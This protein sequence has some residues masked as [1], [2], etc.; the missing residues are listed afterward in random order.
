MSYTELK[1]TY[2]KAK[3]EYKCEWCAKKITIG[4]KHM[5]RSYIF[6]GEF[7]SGRMHLECDNAY[8]TYPYKDDLI[9]GWSPGDFSRGEHKY[10]PESLDE[11]S[12]MAIGLSDGRPD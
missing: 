10:I 1:L 7:N 8:K 6:C 5:Y 3:K 11:A 9:D 2:P 4:E 12:G